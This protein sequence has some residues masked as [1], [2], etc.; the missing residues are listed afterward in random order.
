MKVKI[1]LIN[2]PLQLPI[3]RSPLA[4]LLLLP[5]KVELVLV[6]HRIQEDLA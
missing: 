5:R 4:E 1:N 6:V 2:I 3:Q